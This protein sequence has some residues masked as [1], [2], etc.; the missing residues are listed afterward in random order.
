MQTYEMMNTFADNHRKSNP[1][2][3]F[4]LYLCCKKQLKN[5]I[6]F[7]SKLARHVKKT[8]LKIVRG[9]RRNHDRRRGSQT[10]RREKRYR[11]ARPLSACRDLFQKNEHTMPFMFFFKRILF[12]LFFFCS[13][14]HFDIMQYRRAKK[15]TSIST[16]YIFIVTIKGCI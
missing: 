10:R 8:K 12:F 9:S 3:F 7:L 4:F 16:K 13:T 1:G 6:F 11:N 14:L 15:I 5:I 2:K